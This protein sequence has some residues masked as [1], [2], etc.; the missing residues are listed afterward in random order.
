MAKRRLSQQQRRRIAE[1]RARK[2]EAA[3]AEL[4]AINDSELGELCPGRIKAHFGTQVQVEGDQQ[5]QRCH[6]RANL[7]LATGDRVQWRPG[8]E[9]GVVELIEPRVS[10]IQRPDIYGKMRTVAANVTR[11]MITV[12]AEP[13][14]HGNLIDRYLVA[15]SLHALEPTILLN[16]AELLDDD[17]PARTLLTRYQQ[18]GYDTLEVSAHNGQGLDALRERLKDEISIFVGQSGVGKSSLVKTLLPEEAIRIGELSDAAAKGR[19]TTTHSELFDFPFGGACV[20]SPGI[21][22]FGLW[23]ASEDDVLRG[24]PEIERAAGHCRFRDCRHQGEPGCAIIAAVDNGDVL[25]ERF[26]SY[27]QICAQLDDVT[28]QPT[29]GD[30]PS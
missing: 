29:H 20:D 19:H 5:S 18:L 28:I 22:E 13:E 15:A 8:P 30:T 7:S 25:P 23:H 6:F 24:F 26:A 4:P 10:E 16:K 12:A 1:Q 3:A 17:S 21:R 11:L 2:K 27:E 9:T 14:A